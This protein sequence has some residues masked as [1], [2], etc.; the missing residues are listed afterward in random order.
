MKKIAIIAILLLVCGIYG[1]FSAQ[2]MYASNVQ[3]TNVQL[4]DVGNPPNYARIQFTLSQDN[5]FTPSTGVDP[6]YDNNFYSDYI[7]V[8]VKYA[9]LKPDGTVDDTKGYQHATLYRSGNTIPDGIKDYNSTTGEGVTTDFKGAFIKASNAP[10]GKT[11]SVYW[12]YVNDGVKTTDKVKIKVCAIEMVKIPQGNYWY[13][14]G[15]PSVEGNSVTNYNPDNQ[16]IPYQSSQTGYEIKNASSVSSGAAAGW[17]NGYNS[18]YLM[19]YEISQGA[20]A[21]FLNML[22]TTEATNRFY[23][24]KD[25]EYAITL[26]SSNPY[27]QRYAAVVRPRA[28]NDLS[29]NDDMAYASWA[30]LRPM[31]EMEFEKAARGTSTGPNAKARFPWG[32][33][34]PDQVDNPLYTPG[35]YCYPYDA[36]EYYTNLND[37]GNNVEGQDGPTNV[38][39]YTSGDI[40]RTAAQTGVSPYGVADLAGNLW[41]QVINCSSKNTPLNGDGKIYTDYTSLGWPQA[42]TTGMGL[43]GGGWAHGTWNLLI[44]NRN[45]ALSIWGASRVSYFGFR[46]AR[47]P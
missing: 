24:G 45:V 28:C 29:W 43:R 14:V 17:P 23:V 36:Y 35:G 16:V 32:Y 41:E 5:P 4:L 22:S 26:T 7:W 39:L 6:Q 9:V 21:D 40:T 25:H 12:Q 13:G 42:S 34:Y 2:L 15:N 30:G 31:T 46:C 27:G 18:F 33:T 1:L 44:S 19:K 8:F 37:Q 20:Y 3:V 11:F 38:G 10:A 47:T